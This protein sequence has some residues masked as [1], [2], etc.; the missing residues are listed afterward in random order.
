MICIRAFEVT[1]DVGALT[2]IFRRCAY[3][4]EHLPEMLRVELCRHDHRS[5]AEAQACLEARDFAGTIWTEEDLLKHMKEGVPAYGS[6][7]RNVP[8]STSR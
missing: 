1:D 8:L 5:P 7:K 4:S 3:W 2:G 6:A